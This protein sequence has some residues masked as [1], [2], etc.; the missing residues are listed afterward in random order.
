MCGVIPAMLVMETLHALGIEFDV[1]TIGY[2]TSAKTSNDFQRVVGYAACR[3]AA[4]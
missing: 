3:F 4:R 1:E 2:D